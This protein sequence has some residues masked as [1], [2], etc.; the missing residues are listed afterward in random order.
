VTEISR[1][2]TEWERFAVSVGV[3]ETAP[4]EQPVA[5]EEELLLADRIA[6]ALIIRQRHRAAAWGVVMVWVMVVWTVAVVTV[7][8]IIH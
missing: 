7:C 8:A 3:P 6:E 2:K 1:G 5:D 4:V